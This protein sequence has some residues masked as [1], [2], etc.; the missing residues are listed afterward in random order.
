M[1]LCAVLL[2]LVDIHSIIGACVLFVYIEKFRSLSKRRAN[3]FMSNKSK[4]VKQ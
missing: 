3:F 2:L 1:P 4:Q